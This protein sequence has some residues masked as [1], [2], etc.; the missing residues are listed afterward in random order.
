MGSDE[1]AT[2]SPDPRITRR[3][4][5]GAGTAV[6]AAALATCGLTRGAGSPGPTAASLGPADIVLRPGPSTVELGTRKAAT[7]TYGGALP[8][9]EVRLQQGKGVRIRVDNALP[10]PTSIH[11]HGV[12]LRNPADGVPGL[13][14]PEIAPGASFMYDF[15][16]PDA[17]TFFLH[18]H[19]GMQF[20]RG[21]YA[22]LIV[23]ARREELSPVAASG[24]CSWPAAP[25]RVRSCSWLLPVLAERHPGRRWSGRRRQ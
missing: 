10:E 18:S 4:A 25:P 23:E 7:W 16:P 2:A 6:G 3:Q 9:R 20:D 12:R 17:G 14:Q 19:Q 11:W 24:V 15:T 22:P 13:T 5:I 8:G 1:D 21:L